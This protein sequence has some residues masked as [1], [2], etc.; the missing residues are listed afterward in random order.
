MNLALAAL[1]SLAA[2]AAP[3][4]PVPLVSTFSIVARDPSRGD[5]SVAVQSQFPNG[6]G[7]IPDARAGNGTV[8]TRPIR[9]DGR[10][11]REILGPF[12]KK[13]APIP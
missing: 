2:G 11:E 5:R 1:A 4:R 12:R 8:A 10:I 9:Q 6:R 7:A 13:E 3:A